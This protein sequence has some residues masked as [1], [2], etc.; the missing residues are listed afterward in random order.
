MDFETRF[1]IEKRARLFDAT[2]EQIKADITNNIKAA[3]EKLTA[4][5]QKL[6]ND[7]E[8]EFSVNP[9][10]EFLGSETHTKEYIKSILLRSVP[11]NF[12]PDEERFYSLLKEIDALK[13]WNRKKKKEVNLFDSIPQNLKAKTV[14]CDSI[15]V[16]W[17]EKKCDC[18]YEVELRSSLSPIEN[19][20]HSQKH[21]YTFCGLVPGTDYSIRVCTIA[22]GDGNKSLWSDPI[23]VHT[24]VDI[25]KCGW[26]KCPGY[27]DENKKYSVDR[28]PRI[29]TKIGGNWCT[30]IGN[31]PLPNNK[32]TSWSIKILRSEKN[33]GEDIHIGVAPSGINQNENDSNYNKCGWYFY[34]GYSGLWSGP[35]HE[36][37]GN[38]Y[39]PRKENGQ[40]VHTGD[41][42]GVVMDTTNGELSFVLDRVNHGVAFDGIPLDKP[43]VPCVLLKYDGDS[44]EL[45]P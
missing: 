34:C 1:E 31:T 5:E 32:V 37:K 6:L 3:I 20:Y 15:S 7:V 8:T 39:G 33:N 4:T 2:K 27:V 42:I 29:A 40:Y 22:N 21:E 25:S 23:L 13:S 36:S 17:D 11:T 14:T 41:S 24:E 28:N 43:L 9:F 18:F 16:M 30:I 10:A 45:I 26:K 44:V 35:P 12:G 38:Q 19:I